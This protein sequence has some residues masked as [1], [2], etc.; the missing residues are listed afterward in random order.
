MHSITWK[1][2]FCPQV[3]HKATLDVDEVGTT[4][5]ALTIIRFTARTG[6]RILN[7][8]KPFM[9][10]IIDQKTKNILFMGKIVNPKK[11]EITE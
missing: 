8:N 1:F 10:F 5:T 6:P 11:S 9:I 2:Y 4:A 7:F 3:V